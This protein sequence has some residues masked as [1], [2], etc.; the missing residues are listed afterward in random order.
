MVLHLVAPLPYY[1]FEYIS[2]YILF[3]ENFMDTSFTQPRPA[4]LLMQQLYT[5]VFQQGNLALIETLFTPDFIDHS[6]PSQMPGPLG[7]ATYVN[8]VRLGFPDLVVIIEDL[9]VEENKV[10]ARTTWSG[11]HLG[12]YEGIVPTGKRTCRTLIQIFSFVDGKIAEEW[13]EGN[14]MLASLLTEHC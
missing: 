6:T 8:E 14:G 13:N 3:W 10:V 4:M 1:F 12:F 7:V 2:S 9:I 5:E 11:T